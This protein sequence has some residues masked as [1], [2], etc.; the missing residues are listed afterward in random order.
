[1]FGAACNSYLHREH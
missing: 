1:M